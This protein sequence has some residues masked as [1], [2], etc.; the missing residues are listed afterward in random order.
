MNIASETDRPQ[1]TERA[2]Q[3]RADPRVVQPE[4][5]VLIA[6]KSYSTLNWSRGGLLLR[7]YVA[8]TPV[9]TPLSLLAGA[10]ASNQF[11]RLT[12]R[13]VRVDRKRGQAALAFDPVAAGSL[14]ALEGFLKRASPAL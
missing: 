6:D 10:E 2:I 8:G 4:L 3:R 14:A 9:G 11:A 12:G 5:R 1:A 13:I 7:S